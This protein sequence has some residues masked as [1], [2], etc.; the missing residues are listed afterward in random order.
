MSNIEVVQRYID[1][2]NSHDVQAI[3]K[4]FSEG[5][6]YVDPAVGQQVSGEAM[7]G[8]LK[9]LFASF[10]D[11]KYEVTSMMSQGDTVVFEWVMQGKNSGD[12]P[13]HPATHRKL[14]LPGIDVLEVENGKINKARVYFDRV[15]YAEQMGLLEASEEQREIA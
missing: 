3:A 9:G 5:A 7:T 12:G 8:Y 13:A 6:T 2:S 11:L 14:T 1:A 10:P 15:S 4:E